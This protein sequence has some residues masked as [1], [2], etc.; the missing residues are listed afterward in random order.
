METTMGRKPIGKV[1][2]SG[3]ERVRRY[4]LKHAADQPVTKQPNAVTKPASPDTDPVLQAALAALRRE[5]S[6]KRRSKPGTIHWLEDERGVP[7]RVSAEIFWAAGVAYWQADIAEL[8]DKNAALAQQLAVAKARIA[9]LEAE[10]ARE[11]RAQQMTTATVKTC[12]TFASAD[13]GDPRNG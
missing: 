7:K 9:E 2:M 10:L 5:L 3:A 6:K 1:A 13:S 4:R 8:K 12:E 11:P